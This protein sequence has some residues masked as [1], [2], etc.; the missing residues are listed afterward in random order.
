M[1]NNFVQCDKSLA[2]MVELGIEVTRKQPYSL[3]RLRLVR[4]SLE[5]D[6]LTWNHAAMC[7]HALV[8]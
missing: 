3:R 5:R 1:H 8:F 7:D 4:Q 6:H 2:K